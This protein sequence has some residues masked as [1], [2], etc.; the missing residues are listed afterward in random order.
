MSAKLGETLLRDN[1]ITPQQLKEA[2]DHQSLNGG[3]LASTLVKLGILSDEDVTAV[4][5]R[6]YGV[7]SV[8]LEL[9]EVDPAAIY[10]HKN[11]RGVTG[12]DCDIFDYEDRPGSVMQRVPGN[13]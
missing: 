12:I 3:R 10:S 1:L 5:R 13:T 4:L 9:F 7:S 6:Q 8:N 11:P 2:L